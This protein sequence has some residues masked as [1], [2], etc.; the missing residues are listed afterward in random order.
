M[1]DLVYEDV[2]TEQLKPYPSN[3]RKGDVSLIV[4]SLKHHGQYRPI[5]ANKRNGQIA[6]GHHLWM[7]AKELKYPTVSVCWIDVDE[8]EHKRILLVD[9]RTS[10]IGSYD[11]ELL[12]QILEGMENPT[13]GTGYDQSI[14]DKLINKFNENDIQI[15]AEQ[16][17]IPVQWGIVVECVDEK[18]QIDLLNEFIDRNYSVRALMS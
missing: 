9:N 18:Q 12:K 17:D 15:D 11:D 2:P 5:V 13:I 7:A 1:S 16:D 6:A 14:L 4:E 3:P 10:D 8:D